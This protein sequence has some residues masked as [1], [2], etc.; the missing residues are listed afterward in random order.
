MFEDISRFYR[1]RL[2]DSS[3]LVFAKRAVEIRENNLKKFSSV[4]SERRA[5]HYS[6]LLKQA[7]NLY[8]SCYHDRKHHAENDIADAAD[9]SFIERTC[10][11]RNRP[12]AKISARR[13]Q[14]GSSS[15]L[16]FGRSNHKQLSTSYTVGLQ[17]SESKIYN[18]RIDSLSTLADIIE[19]EIASQSSE[20]R[21]MMASDIP[22]LQAVSRA[23]PHGSCLVEYFK[24]LYMNSERK[25]EP[26]CLA[27]VLQSRAKNPIFGDIGPQKKLI[28]R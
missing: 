18:H 15:S 25:R 19:S 17:G 23:L 10:I 21:T 24:Y 3:A 4:M 5:L 6:K 12:T 7:V 1:K 27:L 2:D 22:T 20:Y 14:S 13:K 26:R 28:K 16:R 11:G 8:F 9:D